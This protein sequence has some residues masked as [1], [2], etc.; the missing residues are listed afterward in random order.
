MLAPLEDWCSVALEGFSGMPLE[1]VQKDTSTVLLAVADSYRVSTSQHLTRKAR[2]KDKKVAALR[3]SLP[4]PDS[5]AYKAA[6]GLLTEALEIQVASARAKRQKRLHRALA[7]GRRIKRAVEE[8]LRPVYCQT[9]TFRDPK[10][11]SPAADATR[12]CQLAA[13]LL[14]SLV[15]QPDFSPSDEQLEPFLS[16][17]P[18]CPAEVVS[19]PF[20]GGLLGLVQLKTCVGCAW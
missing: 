20:V 11:L 7:S 16:K 4:S 2:R 8:A 10:T 1:R 17:L 9:I 3:N 19:Q 13:D 18:R 15:G 14:S 6:L 5:P 12:N